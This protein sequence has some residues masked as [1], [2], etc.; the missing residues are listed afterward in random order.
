MTRPANHGFLCVVENTPN[1]QRLVQPL[2]VKL[3][4]FLLAKG[5]VLNI[6]GHGLFLKTESS[7]VDHVLLPDFALDLPVIGPP[8][9]VENGHADASPNGLLIS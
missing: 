2:L 6:N 5:D 7:T 9:F 8:S 3:L 4:F 1:H